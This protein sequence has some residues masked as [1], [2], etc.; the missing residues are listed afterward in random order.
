MSVIGPSQQAA[1][2]GPTVANGGIVDITGPA[3][4]PAQSRMMLWTA[5]T[6]EASMCQMVV[7]S[8]KPSMGDVSCTSKPRM[9][10]QL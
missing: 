7:T 6:L 9:E 2:F 4:C 10:A 1:F 3:A 5:P 8:N